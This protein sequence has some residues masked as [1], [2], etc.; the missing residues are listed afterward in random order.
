MRWTNSTWWLAWRDRWKER[1][2]DQSSA[3]SQSR[4]E[5]I[6]L[7]LL[8]LLDS[9]TIGRASLRTRITCASDIETLWDLR[10]HVM[11][12]IAAERGESTAYT[13]IEEVTRLFGR[14]VERGTIRKS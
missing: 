1:E 2:P 5:A 11:T 14:T 10:V 8:T 6:R 12:A 3:M 13:A 9:C 4:V 7:A